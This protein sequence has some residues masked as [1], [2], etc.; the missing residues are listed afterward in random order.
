MERLKAGDRVR[1][2]REGTSEHNMEG[3]VTYDDL[4]DFLPYSVRF[5]GWTNGNNGCED[6]PDYDPDAIDRLLFDREHLELVEAAPAAADEPVAPMFTGGG[7]AEYEGGLSKIVHVQGAK[8]WIY[9][10]AGWDDLIVDL[11]E[12]KAVQR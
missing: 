3:V 6:A 7:Y 5:E 9:K 8:A 10:G 2:R 4:T 11:S 1:V 12:L